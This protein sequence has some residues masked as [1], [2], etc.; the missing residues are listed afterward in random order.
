MTFDYYT[1]KIF[2]IFIPSTNL[3]ISKAKLVLA[4]S[5]PDELGNIEFLSISQSV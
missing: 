3:P 5:E 2:E 4:I 1:G